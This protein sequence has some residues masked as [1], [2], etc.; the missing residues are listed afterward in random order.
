MIVVA[1]KRTWHHDLAADPAAHAWA[2]NLYRAGERHPQTVQD[3]FP[4]DAAPDRELAALLRRHQLDEERHTRIYTALIQGLGGQVVDVDTPDVFN[5]QIRQA[6]GDT[7]AMGPSDTPDDKRRKVGHFLLHAHF[8]ERRIAQSV[9]WHSEACDGATRQ[10]ISHVQEDEERH[11]A[12]TATWARMLLTDAEYADA[13]TLHANAEAVANLRFSARQCRTW[14][15]RFGSR[16]G[17]RTLYS[18]CAWYME[19]MAG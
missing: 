19:R 2:L 17:R 18:V 6:G 13:R 15:D 7:F 4:V 12:Y 1:L 5:H 10:A 3:Y 16:P 14:V 8:L 9:A 11:V